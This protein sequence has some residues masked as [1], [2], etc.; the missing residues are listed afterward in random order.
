MFFKRRRAKSPAD[1]R[2]QAEAEAIVRQKKEEQL[3]EGAGSEAAH[4]DSLHGF[5]PQAEVR[6]GQSD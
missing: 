6:Y 5:T 3:F 2:K 1:A 4:V